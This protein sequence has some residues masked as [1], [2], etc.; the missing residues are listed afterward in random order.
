[1]GLLS[2]RGWLKS[3]LEMK[4]VQ[5]VQCVKL[6]THSAQ[7]RESNIVIFFWILGFFFFFYFATVALLNNSIY[8]KSYFSVLGHL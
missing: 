5:R 8:K 1:M 4:P 2:L 6:G 3:C 7:E